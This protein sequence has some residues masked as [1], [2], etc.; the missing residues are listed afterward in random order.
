MKVLHMILDGQP[1]GRLE[2]DAH[3]AT[4]VTA[5]RDTGLPRVSLAFPPSGTPVSPRITRAY[6]AGILPDTPEAR[7]AMAGR[8]GVSPESQFSL[9]REMGADCPGAIQ[10]LSDEQWETYGADDGELVPVDDS[11]IASRLR[12]LREGRQDWGVGGEHWSLGGAQKKFAL[13]REG[14][15]WHRA[16]GARAT[17]HIIKPGIDR[18]QS[19][20]L[21]E[22]VSLRAL[23]VLGLRVADTEFVRFDD[24]PAIVVTRYDRVPDE[25]E[26]TLRRAHQEDLC[27]STSTLPSKKY[28]VTADQV[29]TTLRTNGASDS[30]VHEFVSAVIA[31]WVLAAPDAHAKNYSVFLGP[32]GVADLAPLYDVSTG[33]GYSN[34]D[35]LAMG[36]GGEKQ[37]RKV[38]GRHLLEFAAEVGVDG[39]A[40]LVS[41]Q[42]FAQ[43][44]PLAFAVAIAE[45][46]VSD[47]SD[48]QWLIE[49]ADRLDA[50]CEHVLTML[51]RTD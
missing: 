36:F 5:F 42:A 4:R 30:A 43:V 41:A 25:K 17:S 40:V 49:T 9:L 38:T 18:F 46:E 33:L 14:G 10:F 32:T 45:A 8:L 34:A 24:E 28:E 21:V 48:R 44:M 50:H 39:D 11:E 20:A 26:G 47:P 31:N 7:E 15:Q 13:R 2:Q 51:E 12:G 23:G 35:R 6:L 16:E 29:V 19:Q 1:V 22:H 27:Q 37:I 3:G